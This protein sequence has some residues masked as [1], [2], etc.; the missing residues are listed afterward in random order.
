MS[1]R[2]LSTDDFGANQIREDLELDDLPSSAGDYYYKRKN[3]NDSDTFSDVDIEANPTSPIRI[4]LN[5]TDESIENEFSTT[6]L[7]DIEFGGRDSKLYEEENKLDVS[8]L[9][10]LFEANRNDD[11]LKDGIDDSSSR[12]SATRT[13]SKVSSKRTNSTLE[14]AI[15][16]I[17]KVLR[18]SASS[19]DAKTTNN[20]R[21]RNKRLWKFC[22]WNCRKITMCVILLIGIFVTIGVLAW[23]G[24]VKN[25][26]AKNKNPPG[27]EGTGDKDP[28]ANVGG[29]GLEGVEQPSAEVPGFNLQP[30]ENRPTQS[31]SLLPSLSSPPSSS[32]IIIYDGP[33]NLVLAPSPVNE[34]EATNEVTPSEPVNESYEPVESP[35]TA[36]VT[37]APVSYPTNPPISIN[38]PSVQTDIIGVMTFSEPLPQDTE[39][40]LIMFLDALRKSIRSTVSPSLDTNDQL[41]YVEIVSIDGK[42]VDSLLLR[43]RFHRRWLQTGSLVAYQIVV[44]ADC[45]LSGCTDVDTVADDL[46]SRVK[47][48]MIKSVASG[49]FSSTLEVNMI[50]SSGGSLEYVSGVE[51]GDFSEPTVTVLSPTGDHGANETS[52]TESMTPSDLLTTPNETNSTFS[53]NE[54]DTIN[55]ISATDSSTDVGDEPLTSNATIALEDNNVTSNSI[56]KPDGDGTFPFNATFG[57]NEMLPPYPSNLTSTPGAVANETLSSFSNSTLDGNE[58]SSAVD[59]NSATI[60]FNVSAFNEFFSPSSTLVANDTFP[61]SYVNETSSNTTEELLTANPEDAIAN[62]ME[63][64]VM[65][66]STAFNVTVETFSPSAMLIANETFPVSYVNETSSNTTEELLT[67]TPEDSIANMMENLAMDNSTAFNV[68]VESAAAETR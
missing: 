63:N 22:V 26:Q 47:N 41:I 40:D 59:G 23:L 53:L 39:A 9:G 58:S 43:R 3:H 19:I 5:Y 46:F 67:A 68:T 2:R 56:L 37:A 50:S 1:R 20:I 12:G 15:R 10:L 30:L 57:G 28:V 6:K 52:N 49:A 42:A 38:V 16:P 17:K 64:S 65:D 34:T 14:S 51:L 7:E 24:A 36:P 31:P 18:R 48:E 13:S 54:T 8:E 32:S 62:V 4:C 60:S 35:S 21:R 45:N 33:G 44:L 27:G 11:I 29:N 55:A 66:N 61:V 25:S